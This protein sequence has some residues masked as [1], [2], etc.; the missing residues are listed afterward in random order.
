[1]RSMTLNKVI[2]SQPNAINVSHP[3]PCPV[4][5]FCYIPL[6]S[7]NKSVSRKPGS[8]TI[9]ICYKKILKLNIHF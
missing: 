9:E 2:S 6:M 5:W 7:T 4:L 1:M 3:N 8:E